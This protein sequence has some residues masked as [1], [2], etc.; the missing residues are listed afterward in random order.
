[1]QI[2]NPHDKFF[3]ETFGRISLAKEYLHQHL[4]ASVSRIVDLDTLEPQ[5]D[6]FINKGLR[7]SFSDLL[8][9]AEIDQREG[10]IYFLFEHKSQPSRDIAFQLLRYM[11]EI[12]NAKMSKE[13]TCA[14]PVI[15]PLVVYHGKKGWEMQTMGDLVPGFAELPKDVQEFIPAFKYVHHDLSRYTDD[16][17]KGQVAN[18]ILMTLR[19]MS[20]KSLGEVLSFFLRA[21]EYLLALE[22]RKTGL[23]YLGILG[24]YLLSV[25]PDLTADSFKELVIQ[26]EII[27]P[28]GGEL[29]MTLAEKWVEE[30]MQ[31]GIEKGRV[32]GREEGREEAKL[33]VA[34]NAIR[35]GM[36]FSQIAKLTGLPE[37]KIAEMAKEMGH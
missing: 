28:E 33:E 13:E 18:I 12:W 16:E 3:K 26:V 9:K 30:G 37:S 27:H 5:K 34:K 21:A 35:T 36:D 6:S 11:V 24:R 31:R 19:D 2:L 29:L 23:E 32:E 14:L 7:E 20:K 10:Y 4:P 22:D 15:V 17:I 25:R 1:M 8:F